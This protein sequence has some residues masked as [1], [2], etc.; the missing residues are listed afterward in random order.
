MKVK[1]REASIWINESIATAILSNVIG[2]VFKHTRPGLLLISG[3]GEDVVISDAGGGM[4]PDLL[5]DLSRDPPKAEKA[6]RTGIGLSIVSR[7]CR[8]HDI[9]LQADSGP[10]GT[11]VRVGIVRAET[12]DGEVPVDSPRLV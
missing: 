2:N 12:V 9:S 1:G 3:E 10:A 6:R 7:L 8:V 5:Q 4:P 11:T